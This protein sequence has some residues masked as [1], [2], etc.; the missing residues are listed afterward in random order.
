[1]TTIYCTFGRGDL[2]D[3][4]RTR[5]ERAAAQHGATLRF[6]PHAGWS[7]LEAGPADPA[8]TTADIVFGQPEPE[9]LL[10]GRARWVQLSSAGYGR[11]ERDRD[12]VARAGIRL[13]TSSSVYA[14]P[15]AEHLLAMMLSLGRRL[16]T[17]REDQTRRAWRAHQRRVESRL[18]RGQTVLSL[19]Y[20]A[21]AR[22]LVTLLRPFEVTVTAIRRQVRGDEPVSIVAADD[23]AGILDALG[24]ADHV[25]STLP[26]GDGTE[27]FMSAERFAA[28]KPSARFYNVGRGSTVDQEALMATLQ[29]GDLD[30]AYL[31][32]T[33]PEPLP[34][35]HPLWT[36]PRCFIT[37][38]SAGGRDSERDELVRHFVRNL[39]R[40]GRDEPLLDR[41]I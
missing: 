12:A 24:R 3:A 18:L 15:C 1:M 40:F 6:S 22:R 4:T 36:A 41:V 29:A 25:V 10:S 32:V 19:G 20:G 5:L 37:P 9:A 11:Y 35:E 16:H 39:A 17:L 28:M 34:P 7:N 14:D 31:D 30:A 27:G 13:T 26:A 2:S 8:L 23:A 33:H 38:H 21:I